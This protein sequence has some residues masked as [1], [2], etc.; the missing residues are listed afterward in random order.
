MGA[1]FAIIRNQTEFIRRAVS[2]DRELPDSGDTSSI[3]VLRKHREDR[4]I[5]AYQRTNVSIRQLRE[6]IDSQDG[7]TISSVVFSLDERIKTNNIQIQVIELKNNRDVKATNMDDESR[8]S[9]LPKVDGKH[10]V[11]SPLWMKVCC[12]SNA[13]RSIVRYT[14]RL[15]G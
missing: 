2:I 10:W 7:E 4:L 6:L 14:A 13:D 1:L 11:S 15:L 8:R 12:Q 5:P 3:R 9:R